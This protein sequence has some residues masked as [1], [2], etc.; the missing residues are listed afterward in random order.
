MR[1]F[2]VN[3]KFI[4][5]QDLTKSIESMCSGL[6]VTE[7]HFTFSVPGELTDMEWNH[8]D[9]MHRPYIHHTYEEALRIAV[10]ENFAVS[11][12]RWGRWPLFITVT[13]VRVSEGVYYQCMTLAG[14]LYVHL[15]IDM[16]AVGDSVET[17]ITWRIA[18]HQLLKFLHPILSRKFFKLN[19]RLQVEDNQIRVRRRALRLSGYRFKSDPPSYLT[20]NLVGANTIYPPLPQPEGISLA[21][22]TTEPALK[23]VGNHE[24]IVKRGQNNDVL[25]WPGVCPHEGGELIKGSV[26][27]AKITCPWHGL[28]FM[29]V[30]LSEDR[31][32]GARYGYAY[33]LSGDEITVTMPQEAMAAN[34]ETLAPCAATH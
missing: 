26:C 15:V 8:M 4:K 12:T 11:L 10:G 18:S 1:L 14:L 5:Q 20:A 31:P 28:K 7:G 9:Q 17:V 6:S 22:L 24:F 21:G 34:H 30:Q 33:A 29:A 23:K 27:D 2:E 19:T 32:Q 16:K 25:V 3:M 13:D